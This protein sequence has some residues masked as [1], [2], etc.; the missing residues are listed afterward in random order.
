MQQPPIADYGFLSDCRSGALVSRD[1]SVDWWCPGRFDGPAVLSRLLDADAGHWRLAPTVASRVERAY[2]PGTLVLRTVHHTAQGRVAVTDALAAE[3]GARG[4]ELG[5]NSPAVLLRVVEGLAGRVPMRL[6]LA[7]RPEYGLLTPYLHEQPDGSVLAAAG[8]VTL[9]LRGGAGPLRVTGDRIR[10]DFTVAAGEVVAFDLAYAPTYGPPPTRL[11]PV[12][13]LADTTAAWEAFRETHRYDGHYAD[14]VRHSATVLTGLT[15]APSGAVAAAST[16]SLPERIGGDLNYDYRYCWLRDFAGTMRAF[17]VAACPEE[18]D[19]L[20]AWAARSIGRVGAGPVPVLFGLEGERDL[21]E[22]DCGHLRGYADSRPVRIGNAAW[23]QRQLDVPGEVV[24]AVW[25]FHDYLGETFDTELREMVVGLAE[26]VAATWRLPDQGMWETRGAPRHHLSSKVFCW[27]AL[28]RAVRLAPRLGGRA[29]PVRWAAIRD[30]IRA[31][32]LREGFHDRVG[33][34]TGWFG[35]MDLDASALLLPLVGF[36]P[37]DDPRMRATIAAVERELGAGD[38]LVRRWPTD[39]AGFLVCSFWLVECLV[40][41]GEPERG[42]ALFERAVTHVND[43][44]LLSEQVDPVTGAQLGNTPQALSHIG[45]I[46]AAW[47]LT[48]PGTA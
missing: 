2:R 47:R 1:G 35:S 22:Y 43:V 6:D 34:Y 30:E 11:D 27:V 39:P 38:G 26:Q 28:D 45:L 3:P 36:L 33:A 41:A 29:D 42:R 19:R 24:L 20:F 21:T 31:T 4:H 7:P 5:R 15:Y 12:A 14:L 17:W 16:T 25:R 37:A 40:L 32:V 44:G 9:A 46:S 23:R 8:P 18:A 48:E 10:Q 13:A